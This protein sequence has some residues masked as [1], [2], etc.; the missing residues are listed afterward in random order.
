MSRG[1]YTLMNS[2]IFIVVIALVAIALIGRI[3]DARRGKGV[4]RGPRHGGFKEYLQD[5]EKLNACRERV[6]F[7]RKTN[8]FK[9]ARHKFGKDYWKAFHVRFRSETVPFIHPEKAVGLDAVLA[10]DQHGI[11]GEA[12]TSAIVARAAAND[13]RHHYL[14]QNI[15]IPTHTGYTE[16]DTVLLHETGI[17]VFETKN[18][19]GEISGDL[20]MERWE[21]V[22]NAKAKHTL[23]N[24][25]RQNQGHMGALLRQLKIRLEMAE[26]YS[27]VVFSDRCV[28]KNV[29]ACG[30]FGK[31]GNGWQVVH[32]GELLN[33]LGKTFSRRPSVY[34]SRQLEDW[35][36]ELQSCVNVGEAVKQAHRDSVQ[37]LHGN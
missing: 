24:P 21:Q 1:F 11:F 10:D 22:L 30:E 29:P 35:C 26:I 16:I 7:G 25:I 17:Y 18:I 8:H 13:K 19:S 36:R 9:I 6:L 20:E 5:K 33:A 28:L 3:R 23:Y 27:F 32:F 14:L 12:A 37:K 34:T 15:Y 2:W 31:R 4:Y